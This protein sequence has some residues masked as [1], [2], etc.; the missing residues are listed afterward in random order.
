MKKFWNAAIM[1]LE[2]AQPVQA[3]DI[4]ILVEGIR[5][6]TGQL[7]WTVFDTAAD[8]QADSNP[9][10]AAISR[11][12]GDT[13]QVTLRGVDSGEYV[14]KLYHDENSN[15]KLDT[16]LVGLPREGY[17]F[18]NNAGQFGPPSFDEAKVTVN[19]DTQIQIN[20]R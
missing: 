14:V 16:N 4:D 10:I 7:Y 1:A 17:G 15:G 2:L 20:L 9:V 6:H 3:A 13:V 12:S 18:S 11:V 8:Y 5:E 19:Q